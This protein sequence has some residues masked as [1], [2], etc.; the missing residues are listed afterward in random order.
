MWRN[1]LHG[2]LASTNES[3][4]ILQPLL[5]TNRPRY[6][7]FLP[8]PRYNERKVPRNLEILAFVTTKCDCIISSSKGRADSGADFLEPTQPPPPMCLNCGVPRAPLLL[9]RLPLCRFSLNSTF[10]GLWW[11]AAFLIMAHL[12]TQKMIGAQIWWKCHA[13]IT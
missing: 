5:H 2:D 3:S 11:L 10:G 6:K 12:S 7:Y 9:S 1:S 4:G 13:I 8:E